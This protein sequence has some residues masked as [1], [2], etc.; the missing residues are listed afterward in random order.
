VPVHDRHALPRW[1]RRD[2]RPQVVVRI[3]ACR[4]RPFRQVVARDRPPAARPVMVDRLARGDPQQ[5]AVQVLAVPQPWIGPQRRQERLLEDV[6]GLDRP[7]RR[8][9]E[10]VDDGPMGI[11]QVLERRD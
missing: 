1:Q 5:P 6:V 2:G 11:Q 8:P 3:P 7:D 10:P 9:A 4:R